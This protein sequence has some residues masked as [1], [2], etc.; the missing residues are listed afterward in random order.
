MGHRIKRL[1]RIDKVN[2]FVLSWVS[3]TWLKEKIKD[4]GETAQFAS[5]STLGILDQVVRI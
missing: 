4:I 3:V 2:S 1:L 5:E